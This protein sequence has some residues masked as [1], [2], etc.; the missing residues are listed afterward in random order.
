[1]LSVKG[2][3]VSVGRGARRFLAVDNIGFE[4]P[5]GGSLGV[6]GESG[7]GKSLTLQ[8]FDGRTFILS[9]TDAGITAKSCWPETPPMP[10]PLPSGGERN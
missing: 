6:V 9:Q 5:A 2:L 1:M 3:T 4:V 10:T 7:S 8:I